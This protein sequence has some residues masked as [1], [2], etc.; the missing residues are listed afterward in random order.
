LLD[1]W[2]NH[3]TTSFRPSYSELLARAQSHAAPVLA[4]AKPATALRSARD[5]VMDFAVQDWLVL[6]YFV[7]LGLAVLSGAGPDRTVCLQWI[8]CDIAIL[9][10]GLVLL[11]GNAI[12]S[13][14]WSAGLYR[15]LLGGL[16]AA[17]FLQLR[18]ILPTATSRVLDSQIASFDMRVFH[19][20]PALAWDRFVNASTVEWFAFFYLSYFVLVALHVLVV[21]FLIKDARVLAELSLGIMA[22]YCVA[23][24]TYMLVPG[25][26]PFVH[27]AGSFQ[28][29]LE[30][31]FWW[32]CVQKTVSAGGAFKDIFPSLHT[33]APTFLA[34]FSFRHRRLAPFRYTWPVMAFFASQIIL[35]TMFLRWHYLADIVAG[36]ALASTALFATAR[37][38]RWERALKEVRAVRA[39]A[40]AA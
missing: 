28:H 38:T 4:P 16:V 20:E 36:I 9:L 1:E 3:M 13:P 11:R 10:T 5:I 12:A 8:A 18:K 22:V 23:H 15:A 24:V 31:G 19:Y 27:F 34:L 14:T 37:I 2:L 30:G 32:G 29:P 40:L 39:S 7:C 26:G 21:P 17:S 35:A 25:F 33:G 6:S